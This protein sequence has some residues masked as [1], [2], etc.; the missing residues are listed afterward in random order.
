M[1]GGWIAL[2]SIGVIITL[3]IIYYYTLQ[4][5]INRQRQQLHL[6]EHREYLESIENADI[7]DKPNILI[8]LCDDLGYGD[9]S[10]FGA[11][12]IRTPNI[13]NLAE[14]GV[15]FTQ[16]YTSAPLCTP[17]RAGLLT[18]RYPNRCLTPHVFFPEKTFWNRVLTWIGW[19]RYG[20]KGLPKDEITISE[21]LGKIGYKTGLLGKWHLGNH[22]PHLPND[23]GFEFFYGA[24][25]S[26]DME[27]YDLWLNKEIE[28]PSPVD[29]NTLT[30]KLTEKG[31]EFIKT[32]KKEKK[33]MF[34]HYCQPF[35]H[36]P[37]H[38]SEDFRGSSEAGLYGDAVQELDWSVGEIIKTLKEEGMY[39]N[40]LIFFAS[41]NGPW[42][43]GCTNGFGSG[44]RGRK[45]QCFEGG[46]RVPFI[47]CWNNQI[48][49]GRTLNAVASNLDIFPSILTYLNLPFPRDRIIDGENIMPLLTGGSSVSPTKYFYYFWGK[50]LLAVR[51]RQFK[52]HI[53]HYSDINTFFYI[54]LRPMVFDLEKDQSEAYDQK[55][56]H[57][58]K[59]EV[60]Q[61]KLECMRQSMK[62]NLRGWIKPNS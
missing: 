46:Q 8:I 39:E 30:K 49:K 5:L 50:R 9:I 15:T 58:E 47:A 27:P 22:S 31:I 6:K 41:D 57:P 13:D 56:H 28:I 3:Y 61:K 24:L 18:G 45:S 44:L 59:F 51:D 4:Q 35:P 38:A 19:W 10:K 17:S 1:K 7:V 48:P 32:C 16:F 21:V 20:V 2:I 55:T 14:N 40:T 11:T 29:Q 62:I 37:L 12:T 33:P 34:L 26:N 53:N 60:L 25:Y 52:Y 23:K 42:H 36:D 54:K 43:E